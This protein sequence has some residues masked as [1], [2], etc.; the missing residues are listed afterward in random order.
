MI[1]TRNGIRLAAPYIRLGSAILVT[2]LVSVVA[3]SCAAIEPP[4]L[5]TTDDTSEISSI[6]EDIN[7]DDYSSVRANLDFSSGT[8]VLP[9]DAIRRD[10]DDVLALRQEARRSLVDSCLAERGLPPIDWPADLAPD[11]NRLYGI[12]S[13]NLASRYG[14]E[15]P[16]VVLAGDSS[17]ASD[18]QIPCLEFAKDEMRELNE[19]ADAVS[20]DTQV[21]SVSF[22]AVVSST[23]GMTALEAARS[24]MVDEGLALDP[25]G[26]PMGDDSPGNSETN[27]RIAV[28]WATCNVETGAIQA[29]FDLTARYQAALIDRSEAAGVAL[30]EEKLALIEGYRKIINSNGIR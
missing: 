27:I 17:P 5:P 9:I 14:L 24:C 1:S 16:S 25:A 13:V 11:E 26:N 10:S 23:E 4:S 18:D 8:V 29:L 7:M 3:T 6:L 2:S 28:T 22:Y 20:L 21:A 19:A 15:R 12:W 30:A